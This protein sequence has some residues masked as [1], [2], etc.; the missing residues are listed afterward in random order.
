MTHRL[1]QLGINPRC[2]SP[3]LYETLNSRDCGK[4]H[5]DPERRDQHVEEERKAE[6]DHSLCAL[7][8]AALCIKSKGLGFSALVGDEH[9]EGHRREREHR[10]V[11]TLPREIPSNSAKH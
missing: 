8:E 10:G 2:L 5:H 1:A 9:R 11:S 4:H 3:Y 6:K 7:H